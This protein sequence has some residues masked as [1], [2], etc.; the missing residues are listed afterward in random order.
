MDG[1]LQQIAKL[2][3]KL[4]DLHTT[5]VNGAGIGHICSSRLDVL[6]AGHSLM[7]GS[8]LTFSF[9]SLQPSSGLTLALFSTLRRLSSRLLILRRL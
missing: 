8:H 1:L 4:G 7:A 6:P 2:E 9:L 5:D 3:K